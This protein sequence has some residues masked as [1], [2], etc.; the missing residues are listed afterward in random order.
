MQERKK[1]LFL[2]T[3]GNFGG[4]QRYV[5]DLATN[6]PKDKFDTVVVYGGGANEL[7]EMLTQANVRD[8][9]IPELVRDVAMLE[10]SFSAINPIAIA[11]S[12]VREVHALIALVRLLQ[13]EK[14]HV[15][16]LNSSKAGGIGAL[17]GRLAGVPRIIYT[18]HGW[19]FWEERPVLVRAIITFLS[20]CTVMFSHVTICISEHDAAYMR[21]FPLTRSH[22]RV[23]RNGLRTY[24][25][26]ERREA[27]RTL[28]SEEIT[29]AHG[30]DIWVVT[31]AE[32]T[33]NKNILGGLAA[34]K[35]YNTDATKKIFYSVLGAGEE[36]SAIRE[37]I[38]RENLEH[39]VRLLGFVDDA[40]TY[41]A[42]FEMFF[43][44]SKKE[45][46]PYVLY[47]A[48]RAGLPVVA[49]PVGGIPEIQDDLF[50][51]ADPHD[52]ASMV[53]ALKEA[54][55]AHPR[56]REVPSVEQMVQDTLELISK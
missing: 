17:A 11:K 53:C 49:S 45:G 23:V 32:L 6:L 15:L 13:K 2:I 41:L 7:H 10:G 29:R 39:N 8:V 16:H 22:I 51:M 21:R 56:A 18:A 31:I 46:V 55:R 44:P 24:E 34:I 28:F 30:D 4:A 42:A 20:W 36:E 3:K 27:R 48:K 5:Y 1:V 33:K 26:K 43:L 40:A 25:P 54:A 19:P 14:P 12:V 47:E 35:K 52:T 37:Y 50:F 9:A 38:A